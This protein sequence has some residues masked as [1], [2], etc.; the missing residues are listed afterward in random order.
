M[1]QPLTKSTGREEYGR[2]V[3][4]RP[5]D[6]RRRMEELSRWHDG[7]LDLNYPPGPSP[8]SPEERNRFES[9]AAELLAIVKVEL[10]SEF[11][12]VYVPM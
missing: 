12:V 8:W 1:A 10:G 2:S 11:E 3:E 7:A 9:A 6:T 5:W 4:R